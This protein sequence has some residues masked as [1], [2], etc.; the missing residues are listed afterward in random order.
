VQSRAKSK[1]VFSSA[2]LPGDRWIAATDQ[3]SVRGQ[4]ATSATAFAELNR[5]PIQGKGLRTEDNDGL[6]GK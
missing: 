4:I 2:R 5:E 1:F 6:A 3:R